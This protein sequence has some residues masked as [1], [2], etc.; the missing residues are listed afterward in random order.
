VAE[1]KLAHGGPNGNRIAVKVG[2]IASNDTMFWC[3]GVPGHG[4]EE[5]DPRDAKG[6]TG[7]ATNR[8]DGR[9]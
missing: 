9:A 4:G 5:R 2:L 1:N 6:W 3:C 7:S 8:A